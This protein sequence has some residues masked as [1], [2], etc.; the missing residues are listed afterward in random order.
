MSEKFVG[1]YRCGWCR[2]EFE[3]VVGRAGGGSDRVGNTLK[4]VS[5][6]VRCPG[7]GTFLKTWDDAKR[8]QEIK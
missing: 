3:Q 4:N 5:S 7:C 6:Q 1:S 2:T 8:L